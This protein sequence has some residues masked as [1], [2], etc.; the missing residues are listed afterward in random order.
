MPVAVPVNEAVAVAVPVGVEEGV[1]AP[2]GVAVGVSEAEAPGLR[3]E[4]GLTV[5]VLVGV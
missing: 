1:P 4:V 2:D 5:M 3:L